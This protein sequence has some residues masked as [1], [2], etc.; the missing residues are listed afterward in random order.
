M[1]RRF[2]IPLRS[3]LVPAFDLFRGQG[4]GIGGRTVDE[5]AAAVRRCILF[6]VLYTPET[7]PRQVAP[8]RKHS[9][10]S[11]CSACHSWFVLRCYSHSHSRSAKK[12]A[13][14]SPTILSI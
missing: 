8:L 1:E 13:A 10:V 4:K 5:G 7:F 9:V 11:A 3:A 6:L 2:R 12:T 14:Q